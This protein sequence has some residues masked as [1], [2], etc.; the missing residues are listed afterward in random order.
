MS[1]HSFP[2]ERLPSDRAEEVLRAILATWK[3][4]HR[5]TEAELRVLDQL[6]RGLSNKEIAHRLGRSTSTVRSQVGSV[7]RKIRIDSRV[8]LI[9]RVFWE[10]LSDRVGLV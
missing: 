3:T 5:L 6:V 9:Y 10:S 2:D 8:R 7:L 4:R 1:A